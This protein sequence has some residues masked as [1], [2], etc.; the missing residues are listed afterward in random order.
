[1]SISLKK[2]G[3]GAAH[4]ASGACR[5]PTDYRK[6]RRGDAIASTAQAG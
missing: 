5:L 2:A 4:G 3:A 1:M 6:R